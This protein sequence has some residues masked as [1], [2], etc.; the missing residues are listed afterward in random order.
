LGT[1]VPASAAV[2]LEA[3]ALCLTGTPSTTPFP[4]NLQ[5]GNQVNP[6]G[7]GGQPV[8]DNI[9]ALILM[10]GT[11]PAK[12]LS[13]TLQPIF[14]YAPSSNANSYSGGAT[15][16]DTATSVVAVRNAIAD[17]YNANWA[18]TIVPV[19]SGG[20]SG[21]Y[22]ASGN[23]NPTAGPLVSL[24]YMTEAEYASTGNTSFGGVPLTGSTPGVVYAG[25]NSILVRQTYAGDTSLK[26]WVDTSDYGNWRTG[27]EAFLANSNSTQDWSQGDFGYTGHTDSSDYLVWRSG[28]EAYLASLSTGGNQLPGPQS[29]SVGGGGAMPAGSGATA[30]PEPG[31]V[32]LLIAGLLG[33]G[34][35]GV[36]AQRREK[37]ARG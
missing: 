24:G 33:V 12:D 25:T 18:S 13:G 28:Y 10:N 14:S 26:G 27:Y 36:L 15:Y 19:T 21:F 16:T 34:G 20:T 7:A 8:D 31:S 29:V 32:V 22:A 11:G 4:A 3:T 1:A 2:S 37:R 5:M 17:G 35:L 9:S 30:T 6:S 23:T